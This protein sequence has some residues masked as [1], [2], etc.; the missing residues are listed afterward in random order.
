MWTDIRSID[1]FINYLCFV[2]T[3]NVFVPEFT[4]LTLEHGFEILFGSKIVQFICIISSFVKV[5]QKI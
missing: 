3:I 2:G 5:S 4:V 1:S